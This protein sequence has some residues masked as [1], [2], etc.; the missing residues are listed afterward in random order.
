MTKMIHLFFM[1]PYWIKEEKSIFMD[2]VLVGS[3]EDFH[4][5]LV[6]SQVLNMIFLHFCQSAVFNIA[7]AGALFSESS[8]H[9]NFRKH[10]PD[11]N[12]FIN[13]TTHEL[14]QL[15]ATQPQECF[16]GYKK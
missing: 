1:T 9:C 3:D 12:N 13:L 5:C 11:K 4:K 6:V 14:Q 16:Q 8:K 2:L 10:M 15:P 7:G